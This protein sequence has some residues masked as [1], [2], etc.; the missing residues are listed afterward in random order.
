MS[1]HQAIK[2]LE[3]EVGEFRQGTPSAPKEGTAD[4]FLLRAKSLSLSTLR[5]ADQ[6]MLA[7]NPAAAERFFGACGRLLKHETA[8][9]QQG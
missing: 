1:L 6:M 2:Q 4:W 3:A 5:R 8:D 7:G 9:D